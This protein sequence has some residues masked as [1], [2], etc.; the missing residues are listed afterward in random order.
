MDKNVRFLHPWRVEI[1]SLMD[2]ICFVLIFFPV[3]GTG[4]TLDFFSSNLLSCFSSLSLKKK[5]NP[6]WL[7]SSGFWLTAPIVSISRRLRWRDPNQVVRKASHLSTPGEAP[8]AS[9]QTGRS[10]KGPEC[11]QQWGHGHVIVR[12]VQSCSNPL[13]FRCANVKVSKSSSSRVTWEPLT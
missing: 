4:G 2:Q 5:K 1:W 13:A 3:A 12:A 10:T 8:G 9:Q 7:L 6:W 11:S